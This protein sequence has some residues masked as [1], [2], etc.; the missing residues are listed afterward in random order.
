M[1]K[2]SDYFKNLYGKHTVA[3]EYLA[4]AGVITPKN[5]RNFDKMGTKETGVGPDPNFLRVC[6]RF[7]RYPG[8]LKNVMN[9]S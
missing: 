2:Y 1:G 6:E 4:D 5:V 7:G 3:L 8:V 9:I